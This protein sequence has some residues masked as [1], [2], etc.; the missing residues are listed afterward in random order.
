MGGFEKQGTTPGE[1]KQIEL[2]RCNRYKYL[3]VLV[4][5]FSGWPQPFLCLINKAKQVIRA[6][7]KEKI[8]PRFGIPE[9]S[10]SDN[11]AHFV[12]EVVQRIYLVL[13][14]IWK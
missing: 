6:L 13:Q 8:I 10:F 11:G 2:P 12:T 3:L 5:T 4:D 9:V 1:Y 7:L 14:I